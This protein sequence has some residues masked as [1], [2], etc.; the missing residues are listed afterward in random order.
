MFKTCLDVA[1]GI[2]LEAIM[3]L[4]VW[5]LAEIILKVFSNLDDSVIPEW[6]LLD[7]GDPNDFYTP[8]NLMVI[9]DFIM[10]LT[11]AFEK[12]LHLQRSTFA[13]IHW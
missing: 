2:G 6:L 13:A 1:L 8:L 10:V 11:M 7:P 3:V 4:L 12:A 5:Q 9:W